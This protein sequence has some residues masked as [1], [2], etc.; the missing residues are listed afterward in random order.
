L[1][2]K[3]DSALGGLIFALWRLDSGNPGGGH[4]E[5]GGI[6]RIAAA[7]IAKKKLGKIREPWGRT[8][9]LLSNEN[10]N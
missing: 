8:S 2:W 10:D 4:I 7:I 9:I 5:G 1:E 3:G 6:S